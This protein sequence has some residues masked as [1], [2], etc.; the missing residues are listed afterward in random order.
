MTES[1]TRR[2][3]PADDRREQIVAA[4]RR[5]FATN[6]YHATT[7]RELARAADVSDALLYRHFGDKRE[8][9]DRVVDQAVAVFG[10]LPP[11]D[12]LRE[13]PDDV[14]LRTLGTGFLQRVNENL[15]LLTILI[16]E[17][18]T[19]SDHRFAEFIDSAA[20]ALG[21]ELARRG[22]AGSAETGYLTARSFFGSLISFVLLQRVLGMDA[23]HPVEQTAYLDQIVSEAVR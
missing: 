17:Q 6:G 21:A 18:A 5:L 7:T 3:L 9:L 16:G 2:R 1:S 4:A 23:V 8:V 12:R 14:L 22:V 11:L 19:V 10:E 15:D 13:A 20:L